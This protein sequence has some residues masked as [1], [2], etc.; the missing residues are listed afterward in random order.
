M[1]FITGFLEGCIFVAAILVIAY[2][3]LQL[4]GIIVGVP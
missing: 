1:G 4:L 2:G 3:V